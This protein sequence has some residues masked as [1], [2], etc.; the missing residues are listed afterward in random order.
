MSHAKIFFSAIFLI[1]SISAC[2]LPQIQTVSSFQSDHIQCQCQSP[3]P[4]IGMQFVH[5]I[6]AIL[7]NGNTNVAIGVT[8]ISPD[9]QIIN[10][11]IMTIEG[12]VLFEAEYNQKIIIH[13]SIPP[14][15]SK[16]FA[17][18]MINDI[19]LVFF[20]PTGRLIKAGIRTA[21]SNICRYEQ[22]DG[23]IEDVI[24][25]QNGNWEIHQYNTHYKQIKTIKAYYTDV[26]DHMFWE[27][28]EKIPSKYEITA[29]G[30]LGYTLKLG[31][32]EARQNS[33]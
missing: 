30:I 26:N 20:K 10:C 15:D 21:R 19:R 7:P 16:Q 4:T 18:N 12:M 13:R 32:I 1:I 25:Q 3:F 14:F 29:H 23:M 5:S 33:S 24:V 6:T 31:L 27:G 28:K 9:T 2:S 17:Q 8:T 11:A 22:P